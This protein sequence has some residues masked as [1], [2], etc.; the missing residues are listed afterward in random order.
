[1]IITPVTTVG[2]LTTKDAAMPNYKDPAIIER[3]LQTAKTIAVVGLSPKTHRDS[4]E[5]AA[6]LQA[7]G[8]RIIPVHPRGVDVLGEH[9]YRNLRDVPHK[10]D[11]VDVFRNPAEVMPI[12]EDAIAVGAPA[13]WFQDGIINEA[14]A[15]RASAAGLH[16]VM[17]TCALRE[18]RR[19]SP[20]W[21]TAD[22]E[23]EKD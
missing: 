6:Y 15:E 10:V 16:V 2:V 11:L 18:H 4:Y 22:A 17:D 5:V 13:I 20:A 8:Y 21:K 14:A 1:M 12:V 23:T 19:R 7:Q 9:T 3:I